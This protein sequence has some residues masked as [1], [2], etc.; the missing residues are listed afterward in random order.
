MAGS[1]VLRRR[2]MSLSKEQLNTLF[3]YALSLTA[4][5]DDAYDILHTALERLISNNTLDY[6]S[7]GYIRTCIR[8]LFIDQCRKQKVIAFEPIDE[9]KLAMLSTDT[10]E[11]VM[12]SENQVDTLM[13]TLEPGER[14]CLFLW[15]V[16]GYTAAEISEETGDPRGTILSRL[17]R[18]KK[19]A[20]TLIQDLNDDNPT[21]ASSE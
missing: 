2:S 5:A 8:N 13:N 18:V 14:E 9:A 16:L 4:N 21:E 3:R 20:Q 15:A 12:I 17:F 6:V 7:C 10:L 11:S 1:P 19:K